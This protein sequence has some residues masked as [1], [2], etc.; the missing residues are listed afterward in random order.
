MTSL[1]I[2]RQRIKG[3]HLPENTI[4]VTRPGKWGNPFYLD[5]D[6]IMVNAGYRRKIFSPW[7]LVSDKPG[8]ETIYDVLDLF[9]EVC[10]IGGK[11]D[12]P[13]LQYWADFWAKLDLSELRGHNLA[14]WCRD[15]DKCHASLLMRYANK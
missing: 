9:E 5:G 15:D 10:L 2:Q 4:C 6:M 12:H 11:F 14:C 8:G 13:D 1:R 7:V 3:W